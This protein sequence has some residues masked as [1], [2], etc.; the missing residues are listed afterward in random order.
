LISSPV[1]FCYF[2]VVKFEIRY[3]PHTFPAY[4]TPLAPLVSFLYLTVD[5]NH[6]FRSKSTRLTNFPVFS[7]D[8]PDFLKRTGHQ[9]L[10]SIC[11]VALS[12]HP[13]H[14][15]D[16]FCCHGIFFDHSS[17]H[18]SDLILR[19]INALVISDCFPIYPVAQIIFELCP[20]PSWITISEFNRWRIE[21]NISIAILSCFVDQMF[22]NALVISVSFSIYPLITIS[23]VY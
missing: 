5:P 4:S 10:F 13:P 17:I 12:D 19:W 23:D 22:L 9:C 2:A 11:P 1:S 14:R 20:A 16:F 7:G 21:K 18:S 6:R 3:H 15:T 8:S